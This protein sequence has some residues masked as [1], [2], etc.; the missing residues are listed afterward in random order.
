MPSTE[1]IA[2]KVG[3]L[4][5]EQTARASAY[6]LDNAPIVKDGVVRGS[7]KLA[8]SIIRGVREGTSK[9]QLE[10][11]EKQGIKL[12]LTEF[13]SMAKKRQLDTDTIKIA[14]SDSK[15]FEKLLR[16]E[17]MA[18]TALDNNTDNYTVFVFFRKD[19]QKIERARQS[20]MAQRGQV[21]EL[22]PKMF[23]D[24]LDPDKL[25]I[26]ENV[27]PV[28]AELFRYFAKEHNL[29]FTYLPET[30]DRSGQIL[31]QPKDAAKARQV[32][33]SIGWA[34]TSEDGAKIKQQ[35]QH[36]LRGRNA[37][38]RSIEDGNK[39]LYIV[40]KRNPSHLIHI[41]EEEMTLYKNGRGVF[42]VD[43]MKP[44][45]YTQCMSACAAIPNGVVLTAEEYNNPQFMDTQFQNSPTLDLFPQDTV[46]V[47]EDGYVN[48][49]Y[50]GFDPVR[51]QVRINQLFDLVFRKMNLD[52]E[53]NSSWG[54][55]DPSVSFSEFAGEE[56]YR[57]DEERESREAEFE[58][59]KKAAFYGKDQFHPEEVDMTDR[60]IDYVISRAY[61]RAGYAPEPE[62]EAPIHNPDVQDR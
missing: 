23:M 52:N 40:S 25:T 27:D 44:D 10:K 38:N 14:D 60:S 46:E 16:K 36:Y 11:L 29:L 12:P 48:N 13:W 49:L 1:D 51:E 42:S 17:Q 62:Q 33:L 19:A 37:I 7:S 30:V 24:A 4:L 61:Q 18:F 45:F 55:F 35:V 5:I 50:D 34:L 3:D 31:Y 59:F 53:G 28:R 41:S 6:V 58:H 47:T 26:L 43:R 56:A 20:L 54:V 8:G 22:S 15:E 57:D 2:E 9:H 39:E 21:S 32:M